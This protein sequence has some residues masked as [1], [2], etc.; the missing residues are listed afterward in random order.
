MSLKE[1]HFDRKGINYKGLQYD[2]RDLAFGALLAVGIY[3]SI[4]YPV[5]KSKQH[6]QNQVEAPNPISA[7][8]LVAQ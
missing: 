2:K 3:G 5:S 6:P 4:V 7:S 1:L 8:K